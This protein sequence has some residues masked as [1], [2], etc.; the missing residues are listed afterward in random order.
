MTTS[1]SAS[2]PN[3]QGNY[4]ALSTEVASNL[5]GKSG[6]QSISD[7]EADLANAQTTVANAGKLNTQTQT[8]LTNMMQ[9]IDGVNQNQIGEQLLTLQ[10]TLSAALSVTARMAQISLVNFLSPSTG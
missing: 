4:Q 7:I 8:T 3:A 1:Y 2:D 6:T 5:D 10:N 9:N